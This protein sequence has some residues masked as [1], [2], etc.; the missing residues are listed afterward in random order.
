M[1]ENTLPVKVTA[2]TGVHRGTRWLWALLP[3][4][5]LAGVVALFLSTGAGIQTP[6]GLPPIEELSIQNVTLP[7]PD[8]I[9]LN[10]INSGPDP[11]TVAQVLVDDAYWNFQIEPAS[12]IQRFGTATIRIPYPWVQAEAHRIVLV[13]S[14][15]T[16]F[17]AEIPLALETPAANLNTV[18]NFALIGIYVGVIPVGLGLMWHPF[19]R[20][21][22]R[23]AMD[24][25]LALTIGLLAFLLIDTASEGLEV[26]GRVPGAFN[27]LILFG[28]GAILAYLLIQVVS[29]RRGASRDEV[30]GRLN[31]SYLLAIGIGLHNLAEGLAIGAAYAAG[32]AAL[33]AFLVVGFTLHNITEGI[34]IAAPVAEDQ[35]KLK[36]FLWLALI[37]GAPAIAGAWIGGFI[38]SDLAAAIFLGVGTGAIAQVI[39]EVGKLLLR[40]GQRE[41]ASFA[42]WPN[43]IGFTAGLAIMYATALLVAV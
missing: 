9:V 19:M 31:L 5:L 40:H 36:T 39:V 28:A 23:R 32:E 4:V 15:G 22:K 35:P 11:V 41:G 2:E 27:G 3:L 43:A 25:I 37:A 26:A 16:L 1:N 7:E 34:G 30:T 10:I 17:E 14:S 38:Y 13:T 8:L 12:E 6:E 20:G 24:A 42:T 21:L 33:G 18:L 29:S